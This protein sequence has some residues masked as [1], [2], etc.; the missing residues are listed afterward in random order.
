MKGGHYFLV[1]IDQQVA[2]GDQVE[3]E[4]RR[5]GDVIVT[6]K[7]HHFAQALVDPGLKLS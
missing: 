5:V 4:K 1:E 7:Y 3:L 2:A 6:R